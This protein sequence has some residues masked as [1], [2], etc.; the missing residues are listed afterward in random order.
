[1]ERTAAFSHWPDQWVVQ[2]E[3]SPFL[4]VYLIVPR[5]LSLWVSDRLNFKY[6]LALLRRDTGCYFS[7]L[8][9]Q[10]LLKQNSYACGFDNCVP[11]T[12]ILVRLDCCPWILAQYKASKLSQRKQVKQ[13]FFFSIIVCIT[14]TY[15]SPKWDGPDSTILVLY[16][17]IIR[18]S[19]P[20]R[21]NTL[22]MQQGEK[23]SIILP[24]YK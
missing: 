20:R 15:G 12:F 24:L 7:S 2:N 17:Y 6:Q 23:G 13:P 5:G 19:L 18:D 9:T 10:Q 22:N 11:W 1:M 8:I 4:P 21:V 16:K 14:V 3:T